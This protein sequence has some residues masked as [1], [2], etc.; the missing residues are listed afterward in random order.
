V[1]DV[2]VIGSACD[3]SDYEVG[4]GAKVVGREV[5]TDSCRAPELSHRT[6]RHRVTR[7]FTDKPKGSNLIEQEYQW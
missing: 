7:S 1:L 2:L 6:R 4:D 5:N 3:C